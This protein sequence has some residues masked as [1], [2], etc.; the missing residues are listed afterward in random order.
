[1]PRYID[2]DML[3]AEFTG[4]FTKEYARAL[5]I[6]IIDSIPTVDVEPVKRGRWKKHDNLMGEYYHCSVCDT[7]TEVETCM[8]DPIFVYCP[9]CGAKMDR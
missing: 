2:A 1:M 8:G 9:F 5:V 4:N 6:S 7:R 3:K